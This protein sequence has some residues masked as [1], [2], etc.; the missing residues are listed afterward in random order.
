MRTL[1]AGGYVPLYGPL[2]WI[3][4]AYP[5]VALRMTDEVS[6]FVAC[7]ELAGSS[8]LPLRPDENPSGTAAYGG[9]LLPFQRRPGGRLRIA[10]PVRRPKVAPTAGRDPTQDGQ[11]NAFSDH[12]TKNPRSRKALLLAAG[13][14]LTVY[15]VRFFS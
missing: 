2:S 10:F 13:I 14:C 5:P 4:S 12:R 7:T 8:S 11:K 1:G 15:F 6:T 9:C 3:G